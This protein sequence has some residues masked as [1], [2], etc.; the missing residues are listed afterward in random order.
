MASS[1]VQLR[2]LGH[3]VSFSISGHTGTL[4]PKPNQLIIVPGT[5]L[6]EV[7]ENP[8]MCTIDITK[9]T[10]Y[11]HTDDIKTMQHLTI[12]EV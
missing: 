11:G 7:S 6:T 5:L 1:S 12:A 4:T 10:W 9:T 8:S 2:L 3:G